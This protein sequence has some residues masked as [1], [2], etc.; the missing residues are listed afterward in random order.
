LQLNFNDDNL[1]K[2]GDKMNLKKEINELSMSIAYLLDEP[3]EVTQ[4]DLYNL[5]SMVTKL[6]NE[7]D[8][9]KDFLKY[10]LEK[11]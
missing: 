2:T 10:Y 11:V 4:E 1:E 6:E 8:P 5:Q 3:S 9:Q 7:V